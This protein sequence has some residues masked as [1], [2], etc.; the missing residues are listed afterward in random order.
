MGQGPA[1]RPTGKIGKEWNKEMENVFKRFLSLAMA[2]L[3]VFSNIPASV[4]A[5]E[6]EEC[7]HDVKLVSSTATCTEAGVATTTCG[8]C[9][10][11]IS[12]EDAEATGHSYVDGVCACGAEDPNYI[13][14][15]NE[16]GTEEQPEQETEAQEE[17]S[18]ETPEESA[19]CTETE[20]C[21]LEKGHD[22][23]C[24]V[25]EPE[26]QEDDGVI[27]SEEELAEAIAAG[28]DVVLG[29]NIDVTTTIVIPAGVNVTLDLAG[30]AITS[31]LQDDLIKHIYPFDVYGDM[32][33]KDSVGDG[34]ITGR[35]IYVQEGS[36]LTVESGEIYGIDSNGGSALYQYGGDIVI[37]G[38]RV[39]QKA[40]G[41]YNFAIN[42]AAGTVTVN[43]GWVGGNHGAIAAV[44]ATVVIKGGEFVCTLISV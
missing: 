28:G 7:S 9:G 16:E 11:V 29:G 39:E 20:G 35:G 21:T 31:G 41:T 2:V 27:D 33:I 13:A 23:E 3:L 17:N 5:S 40:N 26:A 44:G 18:E 15:V 38:G 32:T 12:T 10:E 34:S 22:G 42:A 14:P 43:G 8:V 37:N 6:V 25:S 19:L 4:F 24:V 30:Y 36:K 1:I